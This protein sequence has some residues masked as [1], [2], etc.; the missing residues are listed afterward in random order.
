[1]AKNALAISDPIVCKEWLR[2]VKIKTYHTNPQFLDPKTNTKKKCLNLQKLYSLQDSPIKNIVMK[3]KWFYV[4]YL[5]NT[6][7]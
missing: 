3:K 5:V 2:I 7:F 1:M 4:A 6:M